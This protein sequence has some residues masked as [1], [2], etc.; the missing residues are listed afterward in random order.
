MELLTKTQADPMLEDHQ[1]RSLL[2]LVYQYIPSYLEPLQNLLET[3]NEN[4][5]NSGGQIIEQRDP[6]EDRSIQGVKNEQQIAKMFE[7][8]NT[9]EQSTTAAQTVS[10][11]DVD[12]S[13]L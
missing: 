10:L 9:E 12:E 1:N 4:R 11:A 8:A 7:E 13:E 3:V 2:D 5:M 6:N